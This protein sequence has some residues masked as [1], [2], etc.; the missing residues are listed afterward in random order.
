MS[1][2]FLF[3]PCAFSPSFKSQLFPG[4]K[5][6]FAFPVL[7]GD[8]FKYIV[9]DDIAWII[10][11]RKVEEGSSRMRDVA[12]SMWDVPLHLGGEAGFHFGKNGVFLVGHYNYGFHSI[13]SGISGRAFIRGY[14]ATVQYRRELF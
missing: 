11:R 12:I 3:L 9:N 5:R 8:S 7:R 10:D 4:R 2:P 13:A 1:S 6:I 14:G